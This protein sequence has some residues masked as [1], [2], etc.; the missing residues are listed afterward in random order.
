MREEA[1]TCHMLRVSR[2]ACRACRASHAA[3]TC[4]TS[5]RASLPR[6]CARSWSFSASHL[7]HTC[8]AHA[9]HIMRMHVRDAH[10]CT[11]MGCLFEP[12]VERLGS[13]APARRQR[14]AREPLPLRAL[15]R[16]RR[17]HALQ[18]RRGRERGRLP[19]REQGT[20]R[21]GVGRGE[22]A[23]EGGRGAGDLDLAPGRPSRRRR[24]PRAC[25]RC[26]GGPRTCACTP[27]ACH[28]RE[29]AHEDAHA[30]HA[31]TLAMCGWPTHAA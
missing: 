10:G 12:L 7:V 8:R 31:S 27:C 3:P 11:C 30:I 18:L 9:I 5:L 2:V 1:H 29:D 22:K 23:G 19:P 28:A 24:A 13:P 26:A 6:A 14:A 17:R 21:E 4:A 25:W 16:H 15:H 20:V